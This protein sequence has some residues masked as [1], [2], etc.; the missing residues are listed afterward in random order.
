MGGRSTKSLTSVATSGDKEA[1]TKSNLAFWLLSLLVAKVASTCANHT[2]G[3]AGQKG[4]ILILTE[5][6]ATTGGSAG[7]SAGGLAC[8]SAMTVVDRVGVTN[9][10]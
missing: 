10:E 3:S 8:G 9:V 2:A 4:G 7:G 1:T 6:A 5:V